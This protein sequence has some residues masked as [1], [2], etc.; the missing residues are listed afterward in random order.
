MKQLDPSIAGLETVKEDVQLAEP[1]ED[2]EMGHASD[3]DE[4][5]GADD[6]DPWCQTLQGI[7][8][9]HNHHTS[10][11]SMKGIGEEPE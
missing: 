5:P 4:V 9:E 7:E 11:H 8:I 6:E 1:Q 2:C 3:A 10:G